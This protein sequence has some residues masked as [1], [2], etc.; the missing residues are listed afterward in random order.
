M[1][2]PTVP[3]EPITCGSNFSNRMQVGTYF[4]THT[5]VTI[6]R[7]NIEEQ[8]TTQRDRTANAKRLSLNTRSDKSV[9]NG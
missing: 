2:R 5:L 7:E 3:N 6:S 4:G 9:V 8:T 1:G